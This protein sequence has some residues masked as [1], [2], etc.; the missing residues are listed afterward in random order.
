MQVRVRSV[1]QLKELLGGAE[2]LVDLPEGANLDLL[3][4]SLIA[5]HPQTKKWLARKG[6]SDAARP[7]L[8]VLING[9]DHWVRG[10]WSA[11]LHEGD[12]ILLLHPVAGGSD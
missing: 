5:S 6:G 2:V 9:C 10:G 12:E 7:P 1:A 4:D 11:E 8:R 3:A